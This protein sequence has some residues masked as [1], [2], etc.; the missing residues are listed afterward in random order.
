MKNLH[1]FVH[2]P[3][4]VSF[5]ILLA[6]F[7]LFVGCGKD[8]ISPKLTLAEQLQTALD[9]KRTSNNLIGVSVAVIVPG[10]ETWLGVSGMSDP[11]TSEKI[12]PEM[13]FGIGSITKTFSAALIL[14][15]A[16]EGRLTLE[17]SLH[18]WLPSFENIDSTITLRQ[19]LNHTSG[20]FNFNDHSDFWPAVMADLTKFWTPE[21][22]LTLVK[23]PSF[24]RGSSWEYSN[25]N[26]IL[27]GMIIKE[28]TGSQVST[29]LRN[30]FFKPL[31]LNSTFLAVEDQLSG[32]IAH[33]W[34]VFVDADGTP[35][36]GD[37]TLDD[38]S[39]LPRTAMFSILWTTGA[40]FST[41]EDLARWARALYEGEVIGQAY[42]DQ[43]LTFH[44]ATLSWVPP[45]TGYGLGTG[46]L[47]WSG[48][49]FWGHGGTYGQAGY[50]S[51]VIYSPE[52]G[53]TIAILIN[54]VVG[55]DIRIS[56]VDALLKVV[57]D[58]QKAN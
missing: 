2:W 3:K 6:L 42:L 39:S 43:M 29:E 23:E 18:K 48:K 8:P 55:Y 38:I 35:D 27:L 33:N 36:D 16:E 20:I 7:A 56:I 49:E 4:S 53:V 5:V 28:V 22:V 54:H 58:F 37:G 31:S 19:L 13:L 46:R 50:A 30:R 21:E 11:T 24:P 14:K 40:M 52:D 25:T 44:P 41:A 34:S 10:Q 57:L 15:L 1:K 12:R 45:L 9:D 47:T 32:D 26:Y 17:D 51:G